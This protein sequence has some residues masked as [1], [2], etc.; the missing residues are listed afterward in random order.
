MCNGFL[1]LTVAGD[2]DCAAA[3]RFREDVAGLIG[4]RA[5][6]IDL[7][8]VPFID[9]A[10]LGALIGAVRRIREAGGVVAVC[11]ARSSVARVLTMTGFDR[12]AKLYPTLADAADLLEPVAS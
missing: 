11:A 12:I 6:A 7:S 4:H 3:T 2:L 5:V 8:Q 1:T 9:S 10:G